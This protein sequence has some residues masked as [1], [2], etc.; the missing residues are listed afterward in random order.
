MILV[1][2][3]NCLQPGI[4]KAFGVPIQRNPKLVD[5]I[6]NWTARTSKGNKE[7][8]AESRYEP[9][10]C[11]KHLFRLQSIHF[12]TLFRYKLAEIPSIAELNFATAERVAL[13][14]LKGI[15]VRIWYALLA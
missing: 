8:P 7:K 15:E 6:N 2:R 9:S 10:A 13:A 3:K 4:A 11:Q 12:L 1:Q 5:I 14:R